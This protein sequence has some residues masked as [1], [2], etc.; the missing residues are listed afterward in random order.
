MYKIIRDL[1]KDHKGGATFNCF[2]I[3]HLLYILLVGIII[4][5]LIKPLPSSL[6]ST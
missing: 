2:G 4:T 3:W 6:A 5:Y 1:L